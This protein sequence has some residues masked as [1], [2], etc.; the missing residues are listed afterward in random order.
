MSGII[1]RFLGLRLV[2]TTKYITK[3][4]TTKYLQSMCHVRNRCSHTTK[5]PIPTTKNFS[6][7][8]HGIIKIQADDSDEVFYI[9]QNVNFDYNRKSDKNLQNIIVTK[10]LSTEDEL[11]E[12]TRIKFD[13][14]VIVFKTQDGEKIYHLKHNLNIECDRKLDENLQNIIATEEVSLE[15]MIPGETKIVFDCG[16]VVFKTQDGRK[17]IVRKKFNFVIVEDAPKE[18]AG[19][20]KMIGAFTKKTL[21]YST[22]PLSIIIGYYAYLVKTDPRF[23]EDWDML[24]AVNDE[25]LKYSI[26]PS[27]IITSSVLF[28]DGEIRIK[29]RENNINL[30]ND[31]TRNLIISEEL[32]ANIQEPLPRGKPIPIKIGKFNGL[33]DNGKLTLKTEDGDTT[34]T[35]QQTLSLEVKKTSTTLQNGIAAEK[36]EEPA[37]TLE[38]DGKFNLTHSGC[39]TTLKTP[40]SEKKWTNIH[41]PDDPGVDFELNLPS[42]K[43][44][45][46]IIGNFSFSF[47]DIVKIQADDSDEVYHFKHN[48]NVECDKKLDENLQNKTF[49]VKE[50]SE[51]DVATHKSL[52]KNLPEEIKTCD[53]SIDSGTVV[54]KNQD[55]DKL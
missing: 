33:L 14:G 4:N 38:K 3:Q 23:W 53:A 49:V 28:D 11:P 29:T 21:W 40:E 16:T 18:S 22:V 50:L 5:N 51:D 36:K 27:K 12:A 42:Y 20:W 55:G 19:Y 45:F 9:K 52:K 8:S 46:P 35:F 43:D 34:F 17:I 41:S 25:T 37:T 26:I 24:G 13:S 6:F 2:G 10:K 7:S 30:M 39:K 31:N 44:L 47:E 48:L 54:F 32:D 15:D 1:A